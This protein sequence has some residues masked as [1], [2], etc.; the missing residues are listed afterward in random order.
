M[1]APCFPCDR[2]M[3]ASSIVRHRRG[4]ILF[5]TRRYKCRHCDARRSAVEV[6]MPYDEEKK[7]SGKHGSPI[8][9]RAAVMLTEYMAAEKV[10]RARQGQDSQ[11]R[12]KEKRERNK[13]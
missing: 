5:V 4:E 1:T 8:L 3:A 6:F 11:L 13:S 9:D 12:R 2:K 10:R 7:G